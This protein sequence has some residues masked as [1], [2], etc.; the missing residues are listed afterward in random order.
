MA[1]CGVS[2][3]VLWV[4]AHYLLSR[5]EVVGVEEYAGGG[6]ERGAL[7]FGQ[8]GLDQFPGGQRRR[9]SWLTGEA[10]RLPFDVAAQG[11]EFRRVGRTAEAQ[12][13]RVAQTRVQPGG[14]IPRLVAHNT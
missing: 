11:G 4:I 8:S 14:E 1:A 3:F 6:D 9:R 10:L 7:R 5:N 2:Q 12:R 13:K